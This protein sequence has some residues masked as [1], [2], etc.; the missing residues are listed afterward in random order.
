MFFLGLLI[1]IL[2]CVAAFC[3]W[4]AYLLGFQSSVPLYDA[5]AAIRAQERQTIHDLFAAEQAM[6]RAGGGTPGTDII[7]GTAVEVERS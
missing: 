5:R 2:V 4:R 1:G 3:W 7:E 6:R